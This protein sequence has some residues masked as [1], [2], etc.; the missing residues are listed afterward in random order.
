VYTLRKTTAAYLDE[1]GE[2]GARLGTH[3]AETL[4]PR[5]NRRLHH[6]VHCCLQ[7]RLLQLVFLGELDGLKLE[8]S[9][10]VL[11]RCP[12]LLVRCR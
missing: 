11:Q 1:R 12:P 4:P 5:V 8:S 9:E 3:R 2:R 10:L 7:L 6:L